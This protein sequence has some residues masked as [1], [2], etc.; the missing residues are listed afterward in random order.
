M[1]ARDHCLSNWANHL[2]QIAKKGQKRATITVPDMLFRVPPYDF[3]K[4]VFM[5]VKSL[6][7]YGYDVKRVSRNNLKLKWS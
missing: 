1:Q 6:K 3:E 7:A 4:L 2:T 5:V